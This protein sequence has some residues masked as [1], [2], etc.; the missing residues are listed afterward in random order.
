MKVALFCHSILSDWNNGNAHFLRGIV[1]ELRARGAR[2]RL[3]EP[4][5]GWS[6]QNLI[7]ER[8]VLPVEALESN[9]PL[10]GAREVIRYCGS[11]PRDL[12][13]ALDDVDLVL[14]HEW[15]DP[16]LVASIGR[17]RAAG[18]VFVLLFHDTHHR[19]VTA[20]DELER[21]DLDGYDGVLAFGE[22][23]R[24]VYERR[25]WGRSAFVWHEAADV[26]V[27]RPMTPPRAVHDLVWIGNWGDDERTAEL[28]QFLLE[29]ARRLGLSGSV[30]GVRY[31]PEVQKDLHRSGLSHGGWLPN[32]EVPQVF[33]RHRVTVHIPRRP[34]ARA[35]PG[36]PTIRPFEALACGIPLVCAPWEDTEGLFAPGSDYL[37]ARDGAQMSEHL[38][39]VLHD[40][41]LASA[42]SAHGLATVRARHTCAHRVD[43]LLRIVSV[44]RGRREVA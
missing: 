2:V 29:P 31:P 23:V 21:F 1:T 9:Y 17:L 39:D 4:A 28:N 14:V 37:V 11:G 35:L 10:L 30:F 5:D 38:R 22:A 25:G 15:N 42:L 24:D 33:A 27:F 6:A 16:V 26:R 8:G 7:A 36:I 18:G 43:E 44:L 12:I 3:F 34:Y 40:R 32:Y 19:S 41:Q 13:G 20:A